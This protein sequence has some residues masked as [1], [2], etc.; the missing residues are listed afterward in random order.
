MLRTTM[1]RNQGGRLCHTPSLTPVCKCRPTFSQFRDYSIHFVVTACYPWEQQTSNFMTATH[2]RLRT[3]Y[4][5]VQ[6]PCMSRAH[7]TSQGPPLAHATHTV[8][9]SVVVH[10]SGPLAPA[11]WHKQ[12]NYGGRRSRTTSEHT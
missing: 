9:L 6:T 2:T 5:T 10:T 8:A 12:Q 4:Q 11:A 7:H 3:R 1:L